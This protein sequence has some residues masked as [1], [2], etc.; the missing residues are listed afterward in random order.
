MDEGLHDA[1][2]TFVSG[3][4]TCLHRQ[5]KSRSLPPEG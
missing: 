1:P 3:A 5:R 2:S 4:T